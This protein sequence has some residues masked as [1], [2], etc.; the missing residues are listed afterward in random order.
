[1]HCRKYTHKGKAFL[2][3]LRIA[4]CGQFF[5]GRTYSVI[6]SEAKAGKPALTCVLCITLRLLRFRRMV[7]PDV[8]A[9]EAKQS[10][11][12]SMVSE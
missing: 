9:S 8:I 7:F 2:L 4:F 10:L 3:S 5:K 12:S 6:A 11:R 1:M